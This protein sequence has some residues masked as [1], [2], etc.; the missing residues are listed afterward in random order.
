[1][2]RVALYTHGVKCTSFGMHQRAAA[3]NIRITVPS[4]GL[5]TSCASGLHKQTKKK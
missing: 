4:S 5:T 2:K 3:S 1:M